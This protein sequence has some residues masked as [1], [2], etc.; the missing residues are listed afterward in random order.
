MGK[1]KK[2]APFAKKGGTPPPKKGDKPVPPK[3]AP[4]A[5]PQAPAQQGTGT[6][7]EVSQDGLI[8]NVQQ[9]VRDSL[10]PQFRVAVQKIVLAGTK[11]M[12]DPQTHHLMVQAI[13]SDNDPAHAVGM[14]VTQ[15]MTLMYQQS[16]GSMPPPAIIPAAILLVC[17][18][19]DFCEQ[20]KLFP[21]D[22]N[23]ISNAVQ[24]TV[25]YL[26]QKMG[27]TP[28]KVSQV[29]QQSAGGQ[30]QGGAP[31][32]TDGGAPPPPAAPPPQGG[33]G[34]GLVQQQMGA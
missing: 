19:L 7:Q 10:P 22:E 24:T 33:G 18:A 15:L 9:K 20:A 34:G 23:V 28:E 27:L 12:Y 14:G 3:G 2:P 29:A 5:E 11:I 6:D 30:A 26:M 16:K 31:A 21:V 32:P 4:A 25:A 8:A 1:F 17:E 13:Q